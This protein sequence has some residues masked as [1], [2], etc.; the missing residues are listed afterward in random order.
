VSKKNQEFPQLGLGYSSEVESLL[1][2]YILNPAS[3]PKIRKGGRE[4]GREQREATLL[5][6]QA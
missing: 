5:V 6:P 2:S 3:P 4:E 1:G